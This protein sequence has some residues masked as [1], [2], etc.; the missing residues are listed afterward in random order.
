MIATNLDDVYADYVFQV[1]PIP[2]TSNTDTA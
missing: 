2:E 1:K